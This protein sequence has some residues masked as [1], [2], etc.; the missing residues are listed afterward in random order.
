MKKS[1]FLNGWSITI[2]KINFK[3]VPEIALTKVIA[4]CSPLTLKQTN[5]K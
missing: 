1:L 4:K 5:E 3:L 2:N